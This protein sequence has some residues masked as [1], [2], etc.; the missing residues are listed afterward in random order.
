MDKTNCTELLL[1]RIILF[2]SN[3]HKLKFSSALV[4]RFESI[5]LLELLTI[6]YDWPGDVSFHVQP[7]IG[8]YLRCGDFKPSKFSNPSLFV[9]RLCQNIDYEIDNGIQKDGHFEGT[10]SCMSLS[11]KILAWL[12]EDTKDENS[13]WFSIVNTVAKKELG[14]KLDFFKVPTSGNHH[15]LSEKEILELRELADENQTNTRNVPDLKS[16]CYNPAC[17]YHSKIKSNIKIKQCARCQSAYYCSPECQK[18]H[19]KQHKHEC[20][21]S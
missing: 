17:K 7:V 21:S 10:F 11:T 1:S 13:E 2:L 20:R 8:Y 15:L 5:S 18:T 14:W 19:W 3:I 4:S 9:E 16:Y 12:L 6:F